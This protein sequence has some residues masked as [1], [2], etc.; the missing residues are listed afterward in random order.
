MGIH[1]LL[2]NIPILYIVFKVAGGLYLL[3]I[4]YLIWSASKQE[5]ILQQED[6]SKI[7]TNKKSFLL[8]LF[9]QL[10]NP[11]AALAYSG[12]FAALLPSELP[13]SIYFILPPL[14]FLTETSWYLVVTFV[15]SSS[16][17]RSVYLKSKS[18]IDKTTAFV[19]GALG[20]K[21]LLSASEN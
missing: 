18:F 21:L 14:I 2:T 4:A 7:T 19:M 10:S 12:I 20:T 11:K 3:Y 1:V 6:K 13:A 15:L 5:L 17:P 16:K 9:T 8:G